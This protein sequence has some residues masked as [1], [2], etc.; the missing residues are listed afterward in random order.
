MGER[1][2]NLYVLSHMQIQQ[3]LA[4]AGAA[5]ASG[6][7]RQ[8]NPPAV[9]DVELQ[10]EGGAERLY[11]ECGRS[12]ACR[13]A[14][15]YYV[16]LVKNPCYPPAD[17]MTHN[18]RRYYM[19]FVRKYGLPPRCDVKALV[20]ERL[21]GT[22]LE[23]YVDEVA[24]LAKLIRERLRAMSRVAAAVATIVVAERHGVKVTRGV[25]A[26]RFGVSCAAVRTHLR[27][28]YKLTE[29]V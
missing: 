1:F 13:R 7:A 12:V 25:V 14:A 4:A 17:K 15:D 22:E 3:N 26:A 23:K 18:M 19:E 24:E 27:R 9:K 28:M 6:G 10:R 11:S 2:I 29:R 16:A 8:Q 5:G 20:A 21:S